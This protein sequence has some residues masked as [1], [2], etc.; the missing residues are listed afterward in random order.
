MKHILLFLLLPFSLIS[1]VWS[2]DDLLSITLDKH[3]YFHDVDDKEIEVTVK[4]SGSG[5]AFVDVQLFKGELGKDSHGNPSIVFDYKNKLTDYDV[6]PSSVL[7]PPAQKRLIKLVR[8]KSTINNSETFYRLRVIPI[9]PA[10]LIK[11]NGTLWMQM[12][13]SE[14]AAVKTMAASPS[15]SFSLSIGSGSVLTVQPHRSVDFKAL[16][17]G[18]DKGRLILTNNGQYTIMLND[19]AIQSPLNKP[20]LFDPVILKPG[21]KKVLIPAEEIPLSGIEVKGVKVSYKNQ[22]DDAIKMSL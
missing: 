6:Y 21:D 19:L 8:A 13:Q 10:E 15:G 17:L 20:I 7:I 4:N 14:K 22:Y 2:S 12:S 5:L 18:N 11:K 1:Q 9:S 3:F 16:A